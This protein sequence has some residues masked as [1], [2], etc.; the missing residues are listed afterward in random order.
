[1]NKESLFSAYGPEEKCYPYA[2]PL[3]GVEDTWDGLCPNCADRVSAYLDEKGLNDENRD[4]VIQI[5]K[6]DRSAPRA[7]F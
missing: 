6:S 2:R 3:M 7:G 4:D 1:M 5:L